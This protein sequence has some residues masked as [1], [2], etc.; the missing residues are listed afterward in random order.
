MSGVATIGCVR[1]GGGLAGATVFNNVVEAARIAEGR[2]EDLVVLEGSGAAI[3]EV[4]SNARV[5]CV[6]A[7][8]SPGEVESFLNPYRMLLADLCV[9][10]M[11]EEAS[12][13]APLRAAI[14]GIAPK[15]NVVSVAFRPEPT[16]PVGGRKVFVCTTA[17]RSAGARLKDHLEREHGCDVVG[18]T[19]E[20][21]DRSA[22]AE[23]IQ[24]A[25]SHDV[26]LTELKASAVDVA[27]RM[28]AARST[29]VGFLNN[30]PVSVEG[31]LE[32]AFDRLLITANG[33]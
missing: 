6:P 1:A 30:V 9:V 10:T 13:A 33:N 16:T 20:L 28:S 14:Q 25:P 3:P 26:I 22:L 32:E 7:F 2:R 11:A 17:P 4:E 21:A 12:A 27:A 5:V 24:S 18:M 31:S 23:D 15:L 8:L 19:H 29:E